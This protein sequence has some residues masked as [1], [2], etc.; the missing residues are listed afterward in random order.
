[1][2]EARTLKPPVFRCHKHMPPAVWDRIDHLL[3]ARGQKL[4]RSANVIE[5]AEGL[6]LLRQI[7]IREIRRRW[8]IDPEYEAD[9]IILAPGDRERVD[10]WLG[11]HGVDLDDIAATGRPMTACRRNFV[12]LRVA[13]HLSGRLPEELALRSLRSA[14]NRDRKWFAKK[15]DEKFLTQL[16]WGNDPAS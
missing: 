4:A 1:M 6:S 16:P 8:A 12:L 9:L 5:R 10:K 2:L 15:E 13:L 7:E 11:K 14:I 3:R